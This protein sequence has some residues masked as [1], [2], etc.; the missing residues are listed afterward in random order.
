M[1][2]MTRETAAAVNAIQSTVGI[3]N[4]EKAAKINEEIEKQTKHPGQLLVVANG[5]HL[6]FIFVKQRIT[7]D[8]VKKASDSPDDLPW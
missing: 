3:S 5:A 6:R 7:S 4:V 8:K 2:R 1:P